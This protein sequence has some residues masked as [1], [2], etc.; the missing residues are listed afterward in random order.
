MWGLQVRSLLRDHSGFCLSSLPESSVWNIKAFSSL[1]LHEEDVVSPRCA[2]CSA[3]ATES[4]KK[5]YRLHWAWRV[6]LEGAC[7]GF[8]LKWGQW[9]I[10]YSQGTNKIAA[11][12]R[13][14]QVVFIQGA[15]QITSRKGNEVRG[16]C[17]GSACSVSSENKVY[18]C[19]VSDLHH[20]E[21][22]LSHF[23]QPQL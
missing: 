3:A 10:N 14:F 18:L 21:N 17:S 6:K 13:I 22:R 9:S 8:L 1:F 19:L 12:V 20:R 5:L 2:V 16:Q 4:N 7:L 11:T 15:D 23:L